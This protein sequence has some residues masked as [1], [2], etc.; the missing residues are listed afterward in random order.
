MTWQISGMS[1]VLLF[2]SVVLC[3]TTS[4]TPQIPLHVAKQ[5]QRTPFTSLGSLELEMKLNRGPMLVEFAQDFNCA[6]CDQMLST[7]NELQ[8]DFAKDVAFHRVSYLSASN[9][10]QLPVCPTY[11]LVL[12]GQ[13]VDQLSGNQP[14]PILA[15]RLSDLVA[16]HQSHAIDQPSEE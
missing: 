6:R 1:V 2:G 12:D 9:K 3:T 4:C 13:V 16:V 8:N 5:Q 11:L 10:F 7:I 14:Y 15:S